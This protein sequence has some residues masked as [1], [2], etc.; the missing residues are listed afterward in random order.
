M[1]TCDEQV[2][3]PRHDGVSG[4]KLTPSAIL[5]QECEMQACLIWQWGLLQWQEQ[6]LVNV[7][8]TLSLPQVSTL[9]DLFKHQ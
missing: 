9:R 8:L 2:Y 5:K 4:K 7:P 1:Q 3:H 6:E